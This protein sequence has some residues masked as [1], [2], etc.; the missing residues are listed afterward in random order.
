MNVQ[1]FHD[2]INFA[3]DRELEAV[4]F[5]RDL[6]S[7]VEF[8]AQRKMLREMEKMEE[9][10]IIWLEGIR[11][12]KL[13]NIKIEEVPDLEISKFMQDIPVTDNMKT[14][15]IIIIAMRREEKAMQLYKELAIKFVGTE[16]EPLFKKLASEEAK[17]KFR[18][19]SIY[20]GNILK[21]V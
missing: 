9:G 4:K 18:F 15:D 2:I 11:K 7:K 1:D 12:E 17:H 16:F 19:E 20:D 6:Q 21:E 10:H 14:E 3:I 8:A 5:Y 13:E